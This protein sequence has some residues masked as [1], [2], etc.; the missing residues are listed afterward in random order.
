MM[1]SIEDWENSK[2]NIQPLKRGRN[3]EKLSQIFTEK[4]IKNLQ[5]KLKMEKQYIFIFLD[6]IIILLLII[7]NGKIKF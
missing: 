7:E 4:N 1:N 5:D 6:F 2:E 3:P